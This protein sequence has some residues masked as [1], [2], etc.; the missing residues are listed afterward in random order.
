MPFYVKCGELPDKRHTQ[1]RDSAGALRYE[2]LISREGFSDIYSNVYHLKPPTRM[3]SVG[4]FHAHEFSRTVE[5]THRPHHWKTFDLPAKQNWIMDRQVLAYN[6]DV[7]LSV[8][9]P[10]STH[11]A[12]LYRNANADELIFVQS[13]SGVLKTNFGN[14]SYSPGDYLVIPRGVIVELLPKS[15]DQYF[16]IM[17]T[18]GPLR[19]PRRYRN[20][21]GQLLEHSPFSERDI[22]IPE[23]QNPIDEDGEFTVLVNL[24][25]GIQSYTYA[26]HPF[27]IVGWDGHYFPW[28]LSIH[29]FMPIVGKVHQPPPVHQTFEA[30]GLVVCSFV[31]RLYDF[32][33]ESIPAPYAHSNVDSDE[34]LFYSSGEFMSRKGISVGSIT[35]HPM[36]LPHGPQPG[37][38]EASIG[39]QE[40]NELAVMLDTFKPLTAT[41][42][43]ENIDDEDYPLSWSGA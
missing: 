32:H 14:L 11:E 3:K 16:L 27:D 15:D 26:H 33:P 13:G 29:D 19:T 24:N 20:N 4:R 34:I 35:Y 7:K 28:A 41:Q 17:E 39:Q 22:R 43:A 40:T 12:Q 5:K 18:G 1:L 25:A 30:N 21:Q 38:Y 36:G 9:K 42:I 6:A 31:P 37:R 8:V 23:F 10:D 2:E